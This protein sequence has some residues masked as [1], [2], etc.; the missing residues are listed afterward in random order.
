MLSSRSGD[1]S[2]KVTNF[3][4]IMIITAICFRRRLLYQVWYCNTFPSI[5]GSSCTLLSVIRQILETYSLLIIVLRKGLEL[6]WFCPSVF[7]YLVAVCPSIWV[8][9]IKMASIRWAVI[10]WIMFENKHQ[11]GNGF[12]FTIKWS[13]KN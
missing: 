4:L 7:F 3:S 11:G 1:L 13:R 6:S 2:L 5:R 9:E 10:Y 8:L 12:A